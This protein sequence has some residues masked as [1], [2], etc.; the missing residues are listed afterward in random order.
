M[1]LRHAMPCL[2]ALLLLGAGVAAQE[3]A[4]AAAA[5]A[6]TVTTQAEEK[7]QRERLEQAVQRGVVFLLKQQQ[8]DGAIC[9]AGPRTTMTALSLIA[10]SAVG[11]LPAHVGGEG[12]AVRKAL[13]YVLAK[14]RVD[15]RGYFGIDGGRMYG[16]GIVSLMLAELLG[17]GVDHA[18]DQL[19]R[20]RLEKAIALILWSQERKQP[21]NPNYGGWRYEPESGDSDLSVTIWHLLALRAAKNGGLD[22]PKKAIDAAVEYLKRSYHS[23]RDAQGRPTNLKSGCAYTPGGGPSYAMAAAGLLALQVCGE[24]DCPEVQGSAD[25][26]K[27][28]KLNIGERFFFYGTYYYAQGMYQ[29][30]GEYADLARTNVVNLLLE[31]QDQDGGWRARGGEE[32][33]QGRV[34]ATTMA[35]LSLSVQYHYLPIYQR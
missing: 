6:A 17:M 22:V 20:E 25:W 10:L 5:A 11:E 23:P 33:G 9:D 30:G 2:L 7:A 18:Q 24:Y 28:I 29:R 34:Y 4:P 31:N 27:D 16:H 21:G 19:V 14:E 8:A 35:L 3:P 32:A 1:S 26:L 12:D 13:A 15:A